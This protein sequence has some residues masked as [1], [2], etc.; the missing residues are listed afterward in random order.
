MSIQH[1]CTEYSGT[2]RT[3]ASTVKTS[4]APRPSTRDA[5]AAATRARVINAAQDLFE[6]RGY[7]RT[8]VN[9]IADAAGVSPETIYKSLGGKSGL[10]DAILD[11]A[12]AGPT[13]VPYDEQRVWQDIADLPTPSERLRAYVAFC[14]ET[15]RRTRPVHAIIRSAAETEPRASELRA[16]Q[17]RV[18]LTR[19]ARYLDDFVGD[20]LRQSLTLKEAAEHYCA[21]SSPEMYEFLTVQLGWSDRRYERWL[22]ATTHRELLAPD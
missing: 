3:V 10:L 20:A 14:C 5:Q 6:R 22:A 11:A 16:R 9:D 18:R 4:S 17:L 13:G 2:V 8:T 12:I 21:L 15:L 19:N 1:A 7:T